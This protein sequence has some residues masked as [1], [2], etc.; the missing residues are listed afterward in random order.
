M[1]TQDQTHRCKNS[2]QAA[3]YKKLVVYKT[4]TNTEAYLLIFFPF[5]LKL[6]KTLPKFVLKASAGKFA[7]S[8]QATFLLHPIFQYPTLAKAQLSNILWYK[9]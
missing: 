7:I 6:L 3:F 5:M 4:S 8:L 9:Q 1:L 2:V